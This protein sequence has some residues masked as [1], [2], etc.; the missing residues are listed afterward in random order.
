[1][2]VLLSVFLL[3]VMVTSVSVSVLEQ[4]REN[5][6]CEYKES[7]TDDDNKEEKTKVEKDLFVFKNQL[8]LPFSNSNLNAQKAHFTA[9]DE[10]C[11]SFL[12]IS[13]PEN[14]PE[15]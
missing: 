12:Y 1:M 6:A 14:P 15:S 4:L 2:K 9:E 10:T 3:L 7:K 13:L 8:N 5:S 11:I